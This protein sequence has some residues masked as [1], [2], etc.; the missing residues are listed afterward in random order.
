MHISQ[1][2]ITSFPAKGMNPVV[3]RGWLI[4]SKDAGS[5]Q[6]LHSQK[7]QPQEYMI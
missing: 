2:V 3:C 5:W 7:D 6:A 1:T 4:N